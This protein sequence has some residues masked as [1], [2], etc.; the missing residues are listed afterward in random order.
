MRGFFAH[1]WRRPHGGE[2]NM[3]LPVRKKMR[4]YTWSTPWLCLWITGG[5]PS[6]SDPK[7]S[8]KC[9]PFPGCE[10]PT[11]FVGTISL[12]AKEGQTAALQ[13]QPGQLSDKDQPWTTPDSQ[14]PPTSISHTTGSYGEAVREQNSNKKTS[15]NVFIWKATKHYMQQKYYSALYLLQGPNNFTLMQ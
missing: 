13:P 11:T 7:W 2:S 5:F 1:R 8:W 4:V 3:K 15:D 12:T 9:L 6:F 10:N 14:P